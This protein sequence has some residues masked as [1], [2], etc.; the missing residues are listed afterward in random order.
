MN[1]L[2]IS[3]K[4]IYQQA[5]TD[6][7]RHIAMADNYTLR[8]KVA[9]T[10]RMLANDGHG[11][12][13]AGQIT[14]RGED[15]KTFWT[16]RFGL[17][18]EEVTKSSLVLVDS[19]LNVL[20]GDGM[21]N[22]AN[23]FHM[24]IYRARPEVNCIIHT[25]PFWCSALSMLE[26]PLVISH[27]DTTWLYE[28]CAFLGSWPGVPFG[29][30]EGRIISEALGEKRA[31]LLSHHGQLVASESLEQSAVLAMAIEKAAKLHMAARAV[32]TIQPID[33]AMGREAHEFR[34]KPRSYQSYFSYYV[35]KTIKTDADCLK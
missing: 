29:D 34:L 12:S 7:G 25:H 10:C 11:G 6:M 1:A 15:P 3:K 23:R 14:V 21:A 17:G 27:M 32:G 13:L 26:E 4:A 18:L 2:D 28:D 30:E 9:L 20:E 16:Q 31:V 8:E 33:P 24:W 5:D 19:D 22:P 35:R